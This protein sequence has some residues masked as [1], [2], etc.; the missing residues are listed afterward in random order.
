MPLMYFIIASL[1]IEFRNDF[2]FKF[3]LADC[4]MNKLISWILSNYPVSKA[5]LK[6]LGYVSYCEC[7]Q[8][9]AFNYK[10]MPYSLETDV[11]SH[12]NSEY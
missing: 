10:T 9:S 8:P 3:Q 12:E 5:I 11:N 7:K 4:K 1:L 2:I 6:A